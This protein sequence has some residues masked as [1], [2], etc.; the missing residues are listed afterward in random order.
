MTP[1][2]LFSWRDEADAAERAA[3]AEAARVEAQRAV[4]R[5]PHGKV[6]T[7]RAQLEEATRAALEAEVQ[8]KRLQ[9]RGH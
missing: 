2:D 4:L 1:Q 8:L 9:E 6:Q 5:A 7:R 3:Q